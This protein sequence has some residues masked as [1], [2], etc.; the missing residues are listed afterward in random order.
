MGV[1]TFFK[2]YKWYQIAQNITYDLFEVVL[3]HFMPLVFWCFQG[4]S[5]ETSD[6]KWVNVLFVVSKI[7]KKIVDHLER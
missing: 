1:F 2:L 5:K 6:M 7:F 4:V 3:T